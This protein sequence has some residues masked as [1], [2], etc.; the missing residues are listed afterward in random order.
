M[1]AIHEVLGFWFAPGHKD[2][3]F[4]KTAEFD[5]SVAATLAH[6][7]EAAH[8]GGY[9]HWLETAEGCLALCI[10]LDQVPRNI[11]RGDARA[12]G[13]DEKARAAAFAAIERGF[14]RALSQIESAFFYVTLEHSEDLADQTRCCTLMADLDENPGWLTAAEQHRKIIERFGRFPHRNQMLGRA[15]TSEEAAFLEEPNSSF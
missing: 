9:D 8:Q 14:D 13:T 1:T 2:K 4:K 3:W 6:H 5:R 7:Y 11:F 10:L 15:T 12:Y